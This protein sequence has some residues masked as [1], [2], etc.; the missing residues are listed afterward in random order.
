LLGSK[1]VL[2][3]ILSRK[4]SFRIEGRLARPAHLGIDV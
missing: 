1:R 2:P 4:R 3:L